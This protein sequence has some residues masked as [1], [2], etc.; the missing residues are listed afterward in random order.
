MEPP[1]ADGAPNPWTVISTNNSAVDLVRVDMS[2]AIEAGHFSVFDSF[3]IRSDHESNTKYAITVEA[4]LT[5]SVAL[6]YNTTA[7]TTGGTLIATLA[8]G[9]NTN[10]YAWDTTAIANGTY[11]IYG[12]VS[13]SGDS[14]SR[15]AKGRLIVNH[16]LTQDTT[17]PLLEC[18][19]PAASS[20]FDT[21]VEISGYSMD[22]TRLA[23]L[24]LFIDGTW[25]RN[26]ERNKYHY[27]ARQAY[28]N[29]A[30]ANTP[31]FQFS[32]DTT[33]YANGAHTVRIVATDTAGNETSCDRSIT[34][35]AGQ[36]TP[37]LAYPTPNNVAVS[38]PTPTPTVTPAPTAPTVSPTLR[39]SIKK[40]KVTLT[41]ASLD[42]C[43]R[44]TLAGS[45]L[46]NY[47]SP[48]SL[49]SFT[50]TSSSVV[51]DAKKMVAYKV[52]G[53][54]SDKNNG[55]LHLKVTCG[56]LTS[57]LVKLNLTKVKSKKYAKTENAALSSLKKLL[58]KR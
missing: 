26:I 57:R 50:K 25:V 49:G 38:F 10:V 51:L 8:S 5:D 44:F 47:A 27:A 42:S 12:V 37:L 53:K 29:Y 31:G 7:S 11:Y 56:G 1:L 54:K 19:R 52:K 45:S 33:G 13:R 35:G 30:D 14:L 24:E 17:A 21:Y 34:K 4:P 2:E 41:V 39:A 40:D 6:Y 48:K 16:S 15:L 55:S 20:T 58:K 36:N 9:R 43:S 22:E 18:E 23:A 3:T 32:I 46:A 28:P